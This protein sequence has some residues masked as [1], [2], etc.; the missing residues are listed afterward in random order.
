[1]VGDGDVQS[2]GFRAMVA[3]IESLHVAGVKEDVVVLI[4]QR[5]ISRRR[6]IM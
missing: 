5:L 4:P 1:M 3:A 6:L 2:S